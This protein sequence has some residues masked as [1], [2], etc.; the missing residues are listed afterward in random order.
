MSFKDHITKNTFLG[1]FD[2]NIPVNFQYTLGIG[3]NR[4]FKAIINKGEFIASK[5]SHCG[6]L[7]IYPMTYCEECFS[8]ISE[9]V[10]IGLTGE[11]YSYT[12]CHYDYRGKRLPE[13]EMMGY[14]IFPGIDGGIIH[15]LD[16][17]EIDIYLG[18]PVTAV[19]KTE[20]LRKGS[21]DDILCFTKC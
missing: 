19:L 6:S 5:C 7:Y 13:P 8:E 17:D 1:S 15:R 20:N 16:I 10:A 2:G 11:L 21:L 14:V 12:I 18:M 3:G 4:F 9:H